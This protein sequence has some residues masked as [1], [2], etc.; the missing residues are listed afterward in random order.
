MPEDSAS[1]VTSILRRL[2]TK[3]YAMGIRPEDWYSILAKEMGDVQFYSQNMTTFNNRMELWMEHFRDN[4]LKHVVDKPRIED[5][6]KYFEEQ[7]SPFDRALV[8]GG[9]PSIKESDLKLLKKYRGL[10]I[11]C[12]K[13]FKRVL[14]H[15]M[16]N[17]V[18]AIHGTDEILPDFEPAPVRKALSIC[19]IVLALSTHLDPKVTDLIMA[20]TPP[21]HVWWFNSSLPPEYALNVDAMQHVMSGMKPLDSGGNVGIFSLILAGEVLGIKE[22][23]M[24]GMEHCMDLNPNWTK[25][26][27]KGHRIMYDPENK[28]YTFIPEVFEGY[29]KSLFSTISNLS[30][31]ARVVNLTA[32]GPLFVEREVYGLPYVPLKDYLKERY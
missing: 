21:E 25:E 26:Q 24:I 19:P 9:G 1:E 8:I 30:K 6:K 10:V 4:L 31:D 11:C 20:E 3:A 7:G 2:T 16:P 23:A 5:L 29:L 27:L 28:S 12:N 13:P 14:S 15:F 18:A 17:I 22:I 32:K